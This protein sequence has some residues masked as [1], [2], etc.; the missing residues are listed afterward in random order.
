MTHITR[1]EPQQPEGCQWLHRLI[2]RR[3][4]R[5]SVFIIVCVLNIV[6]LLVD[7]YFFMAKVTI[8]K[9]E[10][11]QRSTRSEEHYFL[12][13]IISGSRLRSTTT[14]YPS[15]HIHLLHHIYIHE[16]PGNRSDLA[17]YLSESNDISLRTNYQQ[18]H[19]LARRRSTANAQS[20]ACYLSRWRGDVHQLGQ[21]D[22][23]HIRCLHSIS[24]HSTE[25][26]VNPPRLPTKG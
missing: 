17:R 24:L 14:Q 23:W 18:S 20:S 21:S 12:P 13:S 8:Q 2:N 22:H 15:G 7:W 19:D 1:V 3:S 9:V 26:V 16:L 11:R 6:D 5:I 10:S 4:Y 25:Q